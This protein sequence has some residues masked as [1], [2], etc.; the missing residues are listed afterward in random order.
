MIIVQA[1]CESWKKK[2]A[3]RLAGLIEK[4]SVVSDKVL[5]GKV[6]CTN[7]KVFEILVLILRA[8]GSAVCMIGNVRYFTRI[9][10]Q[11]KSQTCEYTCT[12]KTETRRLQGQDTEL[13]DG[14]VH[15]LI[16]K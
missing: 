11:D 14:G 8:D 12:L 13:C 10:K 16:E 7:S 2:T 5:L 15:R 6:I 3:E 1:H 4:R 9:F